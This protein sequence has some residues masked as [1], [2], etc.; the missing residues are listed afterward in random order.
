MEKNP[1][2]SNN[3]TKFASKFKHLAS[4]SDCELKL[5]RLLDKKHFPRHELSNKKRGQ[6]VL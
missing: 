5:I 1:A 3:L 6:Y 2:I 4:H